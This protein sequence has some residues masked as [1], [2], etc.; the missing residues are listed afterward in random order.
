MLDKYKIYIL[1]DLIYQIYNTSDF[2]QLKQEFLTTLRTLIPMVCGTIYESRKDGIGVCNPIC[3]PKEY[4]EMEDAYLYSI[5]EESCSWLS[6]KKH[7]VVVAASSLMAEQERMKTD[8]YRKCYEPN[9]LHY[10]LYMT[11]AS[12]SEY[13]GI[14]V[15]YKKRGDGDFT[16]EDK[17][18]LE[19]LSEH[20]NSRFYHQRYGD[21]PIAVKERRRRQYAFFYGLTEREVDIAELIYKGKNNVEICE[22]LVISHNTLKKHL[23]HIYRKVGV[24]SRSQLV[25]ILET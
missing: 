7:A 13:L 24:N 19:I 25:C 20:L 22:E 15:L 16:P 3:V 17:F 2:D 5:T 12:H 23:Q 11:I 18:I 14:L 6:Q 4:Q 1:N 8:L 9:Q 21:C 10:S